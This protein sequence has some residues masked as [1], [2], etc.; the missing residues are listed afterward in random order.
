MN[1]QVSKPAWLVALW[2][3]AFVAIGLVL[4]VLITVATI[5]FQWSL[6]LTVFSLLW[7]AFLVIIVF[8]YILVF[9]AT[10]YPLGTVSIGL[11]TIAFIFLLASFK[12][13]DIGQQ[14]NS[15]IY[16]LVD[17]NLLVGAFTISAFVLAF[18]TIYKQRQG[19]Q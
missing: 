15:A 11:L 12:G 8:V 7:L 10:K 1:K 16:N 5:G 9:L 3:I 17:V 2:S 6:L 18:F 4:A 19:N 13:N 14:L